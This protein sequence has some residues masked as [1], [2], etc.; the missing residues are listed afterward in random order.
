MTTKLLTDPGEAGSILKNGGLVAVP[1][2]TV[3]GL[4]AN[5]LD[6]SAVARLYEVK[7]R[8][9]RKPMPVMV[10]GEGAMDRLC[11]DVP[12]A[13]SALAEAFWPGPLTLVLRAR[14]GLPDIVR[15]GGDT[16][17]LRC[18]RHALTLK[19]LQTADLPLA[20]PSANPSGLPSPGSAA[21]VLAYFDGKIDAV[22]DGGPCELG[23]P[24]TLLDLTARPY[25]VLR[26]GALSEAEIRAAL[27]NALTVIGLTGGSGVGKTTALQV[28]RDMGALPVDADGVYHRLLD[29][30]AALLSE[31][32]A[33]F[34]AAFEAGTLDRKALGRIVFSDPDELRDLNRITHKYVQAALRLDLEDWAMSGGETVAVDAVALIESGIWR[35]CDAVVGVLAPGEARIR[36]VVEREGVSED[37]ARLRLKAQRS[38]EFYR[39]R[40]DY[41]LEN[42]GNLETFLKK[43]RALF[44]E[45]L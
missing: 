23:E 17:G 26:Q 27:S 28:L 34:P 20:V 31:L 33:R 10:S 21:D 2:E 40:C 39:E 9:E 24:S 11:L 25:R 45:I 44:H 14:D 42:N 15:A 8:P 16:L 4:A 5:A 6:E 7:G 30:D 13:A 29:K 32:K 36:R 35:R 38:D 1:T 3:Y 12:R 18:P 22:L 43:C 19:L 41:I 37:Y